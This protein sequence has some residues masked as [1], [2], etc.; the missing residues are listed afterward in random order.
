MSTIDN[1]K[2]LGLQAVTAPTPRK[3]TKPSTWRGNKRHASGGRIA[4][5]STAVGA[6]ALVASPQGRKAVKGLY[7]A[8]KAQFAAP[9]KVAALETAA[10]IAAGQRAA[11]ETR[12][13]VL[14]QDVADNRLHIDTAATGVEAALST[15]NENAELLDSNE[16][17]LV[18]MGIV[19]AH[20]LVQHKLDEV[21]RNTIASE[22]ANGKTQD[23]AEAAAD[24]EVAKLARKQRKD[25]VGMMVHI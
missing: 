11:L 13:L 6:T 3:V 9:K 5:T 25:A 20:S 12:T 17:R 19:S 21:K 8:I 10:Q 23:E 4:L 2:T 15:A 1:I 16:Q 7:G 24:A 18:A 14:A 22:L